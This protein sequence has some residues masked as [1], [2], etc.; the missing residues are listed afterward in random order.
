MAD[1][2]TRGIFQGLVIRAGGVEAVAAV[3]DARY[4]KGNKGHVSKMCSGANGVTIDAAAA[5]E[6]F[7]GAFPITNRMFERSALADR[8]VGCLQSLPPAGV[9]GEQ[10]RILIAQMSML[11]EVA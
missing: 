6:D 7:V 1:D 2:V 3:L 11:G 10:V 8:R 5:V 9:E 4:G